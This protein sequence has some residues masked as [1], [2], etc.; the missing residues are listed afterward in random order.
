MVKKTTKQALS[1]TPA[2]ET[3]L[4]LIMIIEYPA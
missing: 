4:E 1:I 2:I 3:L